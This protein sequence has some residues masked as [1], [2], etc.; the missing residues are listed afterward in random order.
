MVLNGLSEQD[1]QAIIDQFEHDVNRLVG[2]WII[3]GKI[4]LL[5]DF[6]DTIS[7][8][9]HCN[10]EQC[11][12]VIKLVL[13]AMSVGA[14][15]IIHTAGHSNNYPNIRSYCANV[16]IEVSA[17][18]KNPVDMVFGN[19]G[20]PYGNWIL[21]DRGGLVYSMRVLEK[22]MENVGYY[23]EHIEPMINGR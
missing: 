7:P 14:Y 21:D 16:G 20:K 18:N 9:R 15:I 4:M 22:A 8:Y 23:K 13:K 2:E 6:D 11:E 19:W 1:I 17:I 10:E 5:V 12:M 3:H